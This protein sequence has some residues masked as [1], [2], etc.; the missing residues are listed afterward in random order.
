[1]TEQTF[2]KPASGFL[3]AILVLSVEVST[4]TM[5][6]LVWNKESHYTL[7]KAIVPKDTSK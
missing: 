5:D 7:D 3:V 6:S 1:M 2:Q 4:S